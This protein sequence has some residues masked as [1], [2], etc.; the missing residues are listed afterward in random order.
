QVE[1]RLAKVEASQANH[2]LRL[3]IMAQEI[4]SLK[5]A[6]NIVQTADPP[7]PANATNNFQRKTDP[8]ILARMPTGDLTDLRVPEDK[9]TFQIRGELPPSRPA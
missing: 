2:S 9:N 5:R 3:D 8:C 1:Q 4:Q 6:L 7:P